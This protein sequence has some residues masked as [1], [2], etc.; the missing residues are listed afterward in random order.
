M[1][2]DYV[3]STENIFQ[4]LSKPENTEERKVVWS[5]NNKQK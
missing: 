4:P 5:T 2:P 3:V 1:L